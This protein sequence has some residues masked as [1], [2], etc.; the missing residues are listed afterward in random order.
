MAESA[1]ILSPQKKVI[2][3]DSSAGCPMADMADVDS[4]LEMKKKYPEAAIVTYINSSAAVKAAS[5][6]CVT[7]SNAVSIV[8]KLNEET[9]LFVPDKNLAHYVQRFTNKRLYHGMVFVLHMKSLQKKT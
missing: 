6:I 3:P 8:N 9:I 5:D 4:I 2:L 7:S 1:C